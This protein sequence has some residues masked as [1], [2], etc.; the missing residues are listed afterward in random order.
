MSRITELSRRQLQKLKKLEK[1][2]RD[3]ENVGVY[4]VNNYGRLEAYDSHKVDSYDDSKREDGLS[5][6]DHVAEWCMNLPGE[7]SDDQHFLHPVS[8]LKL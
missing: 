8:N 6:W 4:F 2:Y 5:N 3:C 7:W 1:A